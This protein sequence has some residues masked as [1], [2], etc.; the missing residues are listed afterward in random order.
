MSPNPRAYRYT[1]RSLHVPTKIL[2]IC[3]LHAIPALPLRSLSHPCHPVTPDRTLKSSALKTLGNLPMSFPGTPWS[4]A[5]RAATL[6]KLGLRGFSVVMHAVWELGIRTARDR[7]LELTG[8]SA[9]EPF[10][11][12]LPSIPRCFHAPVVKSAEA[13]ISWLLFM[14]LRANTFRRFLAQCS[15]EPSNCKS[16]P[17]AKHLC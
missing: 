13:G 14:F 16:V 9:Q 8:I 6:S 3:M 7:C 1:L 15:P 10:S 17:Q 12:M 11:S 5:V 2:S 4:G